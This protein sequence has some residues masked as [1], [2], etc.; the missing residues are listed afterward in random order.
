[1]RICL[2]APAGRLCRCL[3]LAR[4]GVLRLGGLCRYG[5][6]D[7]IP[8]TKPKRNITRDFAD[9]VMC[10]QTVH[11]FIP[12]FVE[13]HNYSSAVRGGRHPRRGRVAA[14]G[15]RGGRHRRRR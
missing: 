13:L 8:L 1:M 12:R 10:A 15:R 9:G 3:A 11:H 2:P 14:E 7:D 6:V 4:G 5:W